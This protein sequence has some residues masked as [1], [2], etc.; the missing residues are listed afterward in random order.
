MILL[1]GGAKYAL[2]SKR[3][4]ARHVVGQARPLTNMYYVYL[5]RSIKDPLKTYI[6]YTNNLEQRVQSHNA[7]SSIHTQKYRP[8]KLVM[9]L[10]FSSEEK[11]LDFEKYIKIGLGHAF[12][13]KHFW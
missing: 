13:K 7:G 9:Y 4:G 5:L 12:A 6:G 2:R 1:A 11:A 8:W 10:A 3:S